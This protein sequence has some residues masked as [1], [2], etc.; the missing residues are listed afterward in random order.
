M[1]SECPHPIYTCFFHK[2][3]DAFTSSCL[4]LVAL[5]HGV[6]ESSANELLHKHIIVNTFRRKR[7]PCLVAGATSS[8]APGILSEPVVLAAVSPV[9]FSRPEREALW[10]DFVSGCDCE[11]AEKVC[12][13]KLSPLTHHQLTC[14][15]PVQ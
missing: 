9:V 7:K 10:D 2:C 12:R 5:N 6:V 4:H 14:T 3:P 13:K 1:S 11:L 15:K 8:L